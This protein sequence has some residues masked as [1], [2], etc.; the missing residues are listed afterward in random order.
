VQCQDSASEDRPAIH[1][2]RWRGV[3]TGNEL[4]SRAAWRPKAALTCGPDTRA[5]PWPVSSTPLT[6][7]RTCCGSADPCRHGEQRGPG[8]P[9]STARRCTACAP[10]R[11]RRALGARRSDGLALGNLVGAHPEGGAVIVLGDDPGATRPRSRRFPVPVQAPDDAVLEPSDAQELKDWINLAFCLSRES[12]LYIGYLVTTNQADGG[13]SVEVRLNQ[14]PPSTP[15]NGLTSKRP[16][17]T[18]NATSSCHRGLAKGTADRERF[19]RLWRCAAAR[20]EPEL[21][22]ATTPTLRRAWASSLPLG[23][24]LSAARAGGARW[25]AIPDSEAGITYP[26]DPSAVVEFAAGLRDLF[27]IEERRGFL[28]NRSSKSSPGRAK[29]RRNG[30]TPSRA[31]VGQAI[32]ARPHG[33]SRNARPEPEQ[34]DRP[35]RS[36]FSKRPTRRADRRTR[37]QRELD[38]I[39]EVKTVVVDVAQRT[40]TFCPAAR[41]RLGERATGHPAAVPRPGYMRRVHGIGR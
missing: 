37:I 2:T 41:T 32:P 23:V 12:E 38:L 31:G 28:R 22:A 39:H 8:A 24:L 7:C 35:A 20:R 34:A 29:P 21:R 3:F 17:S 27:V 30:R 33:D 15:T 9:W 18:S 6:N 26:L 16:G 40:P 14:F 10:S 19:G 11:S 36:L 25:M 1:K 5:H 4:S 13:G